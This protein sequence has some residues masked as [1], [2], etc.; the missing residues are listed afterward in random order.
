M[1][2]VST[3]G[4]AKRM[5]PTTEPDRM[6]WV[7]V[8]PFSSDQRGRM[9]LN[10]PGVGP[11]SGKNQPTPQPSPATEESAICR[12]LRLWSARPWDG[13]F[14]NDESRTGGPRYAAIRH[15][16]TELLRDRGRE[17]RRGR[18]RA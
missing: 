1:K 18:R 17:R 13:S 7:A 3:F 14:S 4:L 15:M 8:L 10:S 11:V 2:Q 5:W 16:V 12:A 6:A 9:L